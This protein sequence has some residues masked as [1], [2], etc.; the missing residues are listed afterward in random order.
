[1]LISKEIPFYVYIFL[2]LIFVCL[3][4]GPVFVKAGDEILEIQLFE[5]ER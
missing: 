4:A 2:V 5:G 1:M 3:I